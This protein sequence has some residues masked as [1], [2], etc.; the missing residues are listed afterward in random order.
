MLLDESAA[1]AVYASEEV[2][3]YRRILIAV[4][5]EGLVGGAASAVAALAEPEGAQVRLVAIARDSDDAGAAPAGEE[6][7]QRLSQELQARHQSV[8]VERREGGGGPVADQLAESAR[9]FEADLIVLGSHRRGDVAGFFVG[10]VGHALATQVST[11]ILVVSHASSK[12]LATLR[13][14]VVAVDGGEFCRQAVAAAGA[15]A[16]PE[17]E[18]T[19]IYVNNP[20]ARPVA[21]P[22]YHDPTPADVDGTRAL[23][24]AFDAL[25]T[26]GVY[27]ARRLVYSLDSRGAVIARAADDLDA[28]L[29]VLGSRRPGNLESLVLG[30]VA[31]DVISRTHRPVLVAT[32]AGNDGAADADRSG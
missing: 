24:D 23:N 11:P 14:I 19:A 31:H 6:T 29:I 9:A 27:A 2:I 1:T 25:R 20:T 30:S 22:F 18:V 32:G 10:S 12:A 26:A 3:M 15:L 28:D 4:D 16:G 17:T 5:P 21:Y 13:R 8:E 7:L